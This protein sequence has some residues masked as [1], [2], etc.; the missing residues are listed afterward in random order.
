V[1]VLVVGGGGREHALAWKVKQS[2]K[3]TK[4]YCAPGNAGTSMVSENVDIKADDIPSL[5]QFAQRRKIGLTVV[6]PEQP[7]VMG[8]ADKF[9]EKGLPVFGPSAKAA[10]IE[11]SK[12]FCKDLMRKYD[13]PTGEYQTFVSLGEARAYVIGRGPLVIKADGLA[14][15]KG[16]F[17][18]KNEKEAL[19]AID[20]IMKFKSFGEAGKAIVI[21]EFLEGPEVSLLAFT[22]GKTLLPLDSAQDHKAAYDGDNGPNTGGM[23]AYSPTHVLSGSLL[24]MAMSEIMYPTVRALELEGARYQGLLYAG[25]MLTAN[26]PKVLEFNA[27]FGDPETQPLMVRLKSDVLD[28]MLACEN[29]TLDRHRLEWDSRFSVCVVMAAEGYPGS[30]NQGMVIDGLES[31]EVS[32]DVTVFH[33]G[34]R[35]KNGKMTCNGGRVLGVTALAETLNNAIGNA[36]SVV[37]KIQWDGVHYRNDIGRRN[38]EKKCYSKKA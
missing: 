18:C 13:I 12:K 38:E 28:I 24:K 29:G 15:G 37:D 14:A 21:E 30:Y 27:R 16:V 26:G 4:V 31:A 2:P 19:Q 23:G 1:E 11:G 17:I 10:R 35:L 32:D 7:L 36:Y 6:G 5:L 33:A 20:E 8:L 25:L 3:V 9:R 34:T 22:D